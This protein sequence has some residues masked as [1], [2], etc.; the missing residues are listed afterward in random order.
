MKYILPIFTK[1]FYFLSMVALLGLI[2]MVVYS[3]YQALYPFKT[4]EVHNSPYPVVTPLVKAGGIFTYY[5]DYCRFTNIQ[6]SV[7]RSLVGIDN[8]GN[9]LIIPLPGSI[10]STPI[11]CYKTNVS[12]RLIIPNATPPGIYHMV[13]TPSYVVNSHQTQTRTYQTQSFEIL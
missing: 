2:V 7:S 8:L 3:T 13:I 4:I 11:G 5:V 12:I 10:N 6:A 1:A 9:P